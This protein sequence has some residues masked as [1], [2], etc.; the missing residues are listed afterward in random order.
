MKNYYQTYY[1]YFRI[2]CDFRKSIMLMKKS[3][4]LVRISRAVFD[5][6]RK[7][8]IIYVNRSHCFH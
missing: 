5:L 3:Y 8:G 6:F 4:S 2:E 1:I 7:T